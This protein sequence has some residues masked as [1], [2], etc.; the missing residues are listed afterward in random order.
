MTRRWPRAVDFAEAW[1]KRGHIATTPPRRTVQMTSG[2]RRFHLSSSRRFLGAAERMASRT[3]AKQRTRIVILSEL[4]ASGKLGQYLVE[5]VVK[6]SWQLDQ[7][8]KS[9]PAHLAKWI[10]CGG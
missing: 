1:S 4:N 2:T 9:E 5:R 10:A 8:D 3:R 7:A 6:I